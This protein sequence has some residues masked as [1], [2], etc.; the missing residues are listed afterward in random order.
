MTML[1]LLGNEGA[2]RAGRDRL[3]L[4]TALMDAPGF[5]PLYRSDLI[6]IPPRHPVYGWECAADACGRIR[7]RWGGL[8]HW[9][10]PQWRE[11]RNAGSSRAAFLAAA[12]PG[13]PK[14]GIARARCMICP[15]RPAR[16]RGIQLCQIHEARWRR[17]GGPANEALQEWLNEQAPFPG[18]GECQVEACPDLAAEGGLCPGHVDR[19]RKEGWPGGTWVPKSRR[20]DPDGPVRYA[21]KAEFLKWCAMAAPAYR[22]GLIN[23]RGLRPLI[24]AEIQWGLHQH[25][26]IKKREV[27]EM[28]C[29]QRL[30]DLCRTSEMASLAEF[31]GTGCPGLTRFSKGSSSSRIRMMFLEIAG[32]LRCIYCTPADARDAGYIETD[33]FGR[34]FSRA[35]SHFCLTGVS[36]RWLRDLLWE[37]LAEILRAPRCPRSR[38]TFDEARR[39]CIE[40]SAFLQ[41]D[42]PGGGH[43]PRALRAEHAQRFVADQ[44]HR[45]RHGLKTLGM[46]RADGKPS[47]VTDVALRKVFNSGRRVMFWALETGQADQIGLDRGFITAFPNAGRSSPQRSRN[48]F[49]DDVARALADEASL[50]ELDKP[51]PAGCGLRDAW[52]AIV[53]T[54][55]RCSEV[56]TLKAGCIGR[57]RGLPMLW[58][59]QAKVGNYNEG[60]RIPEYLYARIEVRRHKT[61]TRFEH[62]HGRHPAPGE[63]TRIALFP[64]RVRNPAEEEPITYGHFNRQFRQWLGSLDLGGHVAHQARHTL[65]TKLLAAGASLAHIRKYPGHVSDRMAEHYAKVS[66]CGLDDLLNAVWVAGPGPASPGELLSGSAAPISRQEA[67][68][69]A[70]DLSRRS[71]PAEGGFCTWQPV[72]DGGACP[73][74][75]DCAN[76]DK[77]VLSGADLLYWRRKQEQWRSLAERAPTGEVAGFLHKA[78]EPTAR[79]IE[80]LEKALAGLGLLD[81]AL[82]L[83]LRR[84]QD[85][86]QR[87]WAVNFRAS[88]LT[89]LTDPE[90]KAG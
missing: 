29:I 75:L 28:S 79:A 71:T 40:L 22:T 6:A 68:T 54:G 45:Y 78:F 63:R 36:Q 38:N 60:I 14:Q 9:R 21:G 76:C 58:H 26:Q 53:Y 70:V 33:H 87:I 80:G 85:Y 56:L 1:K 41:I 44:R 86:F 18:Y 7:L 43:D 48:P 15:D 49:T 66:H 77:F 37:H 51:G 84:P 69:L 52:E 65:A 31:T 5:D 73:W 13:P 27:W 50:R 30:A 17:A 61:L 11:A 89:G 90:E 47:L 55:R 39:A 2:S 81:Q 35:G 12:S 83:D 74:N 16:L 23:L 10:A 32:G 59:D 62:R 42:A 34:R 8:C 4:L 46:V 57:Y 72:V 64:T 3:E 82:A 20:D 19:Y 88:D 25:A 67:M 24:K